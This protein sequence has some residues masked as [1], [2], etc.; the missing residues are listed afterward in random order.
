MSDSKTKKTEPQTLASE[1]MDI[2]EQAR[3]N[4]VH[5]IEFSR[6]QMYWTIGKR[7]VESLKHGHDGDVDV[8]SLRKDLTKELSSDLDCAFELR[9]LERCCKFYQLYQD[10]SFLN[11]LLSWEH[12]QLLLAID[13]SDKRQFYELQAI[14]DGWS[15]PK[16]EQQI[17]SLLYER[18]L[19]SDDKDS[20][21][22]KASKEPNPT[23]QLD[24]LK[25][26]KV[27]DFLGL[28]GKASYYEDDMESALISHMSDYLLSLNKGFTFVARQKRITVEDDEFFADLVFYNRL[29]RSF[30]IVEIKTH[31]ISHQDLDELQ[32]YVNYFDRYEKTEDENPTI[33]I[34][35][36]TDKNDTA[37]RLTLPESNKTIMASK[38]E[39]YLPSSEQLLEQ[40]NEVKKLVLPEVDEKA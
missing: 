12:Y 10:A 21:L 33:G 24:K 35:L 36:G 29:L 20:V 32:M 8:Q 18:L 6:V 3:C 16:L 31:K 28:D 38:Y 17:N 27:L 39:L 15:S 13:D 7:L 34:L 26:P 9:Q 23:L 5:A 40:V 2:I 11:P 1:V 14:K 30:V 25:S 37:V 19:M 4:A 22:A